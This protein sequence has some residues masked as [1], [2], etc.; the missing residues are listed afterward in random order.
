VRH[1]RDIVDDRAPRRKRRDGHDKGERREPMTVKFRED[2]QVLGVPPE[3]AGAPR[4]EMR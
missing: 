1:Q 4:K 2:Y 3:V